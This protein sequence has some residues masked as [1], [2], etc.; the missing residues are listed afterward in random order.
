MAE[1]LIYHIMKRDDWDDYGLTAATSRPAS[2]EGYIHAST[3]PQVVETA[4][5]YFAGRKTRPARHRP[6]WV[7]AEIR[8]EDHRPRRK[9]PHIYGY[10]SLNAVFLVM[11]CP[12]LRGA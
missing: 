7:Q 11:T 9:V 8:Y 6:A 3:L 10:I 12:Q 5:R 2:K 4:D 1:E